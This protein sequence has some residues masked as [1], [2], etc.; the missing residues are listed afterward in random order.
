MYEPIATLLALIC[1][2]EG[3]I[4]CNIAYIVIDIINIC[5]LYYL[6]VI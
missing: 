5:L 1:I 6:A 4:L 3:Y 2:A